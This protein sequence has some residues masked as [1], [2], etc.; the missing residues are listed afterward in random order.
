[1]S[2]K[3]SMPQERLL[4]WLGN[5]SASLEKAWD[6]TREISL[7]GISE[8]LGV[9]RSA[10]NVPLTQLEKQDLVFKRMAH[11]IGGGS[12]RRNVYHLTEEGRK[13]LS[14]LGDDTSKPRKSS[15]EGRMFGDAPTL[16]TVYGRSSLI[17]TVFDEIHQQHCLFISGLPG[18][19]KT[20]VGLAAAGKLVSNGLNVRWCTANEYS[21]FETLCHSMSILS[22]LP[23]DANALA[24]HLAHECKDEVLVF[25]DVHMISSRHLGTFMAICQHM[26]GLQGPKMM[27]IGRET[28]PGFEAMNRVSIPQLEAKEAAKLLGKTLP[29]KESLHIAERLGGH[30]LALQLYQQDTTLPEENA[31]IQSYVEDVVLSTLDAPTRSG[32]DH[33]VLL[34]QPVEAK[35][36]YDDEV[37][38]TLDDYAFLRWT[39]NMEK[40][41][42][43]HLV[44]NVRRTSMSSAEKQELHRLA[45][46]HWESCAETVDDY[47]VLLFHRICAQSEELDAH[48][49]TAYDRLSPSRS[50]A[51]SV[52]LEQAIEA[53]NAPSHLHYLAAKIALDRCEPKHAHRHLTE[54]E[55]EGS[56][57]QISIG[58]AYLEGRLQDAEKSIEKGFE[59]GNQHQKNQLALSAASRRLDDRISTAL[60]K[61]AAKDIKRYLSHIVLPEDAEQRAVT[62]VAL[63][64]VQHAIALAERDFSK[65]DTLRANLSSI[66]S[67]KSGI[68]MGL[69]AKS[70]LIQMQENPTGLP[71]VIESTLQ[72]IDVQP[73]PTH[74]D[75]LRL[76]LVEALLELDVDLAQKHFKNVTKPNS[77]PGS[78]MLH[79]LHARWWFCKSHLHPSLKKVALKEAI[80]QH[81]AAGCPR[82]ANHLEALL[83]S[84]L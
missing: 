72:A 73:S 27:F 55:D 45:V 10:L 60:S 24:E 51:L 42:I 50:S 47:V 11:V 74:Q 40:M 53:S 41:E 44:R 22:E 34:P 31:D 35:K 19:G 14:T 30:P 8:S 49:T 21:D 25:D 71:N 81:R 46:T 12:R 20:T 2:E 52:L 13:L 64:M 69:E 38:G 37:V 15:S 59:L 79:R 17:D 36:A 29:R 39:S 62:V 65:A 6:V 84:L 70:T 43:Q 28:L 54:I 67:L 33:L 76:S 4:R 56:S 32:M 1:M 68:I 61:D 66:S 75:A 9:V 83:H 26:E 48:C 5:Y 80:T 18:I 58:L 3:L 7:P 63:T 82:A 16:G 77:S 23:S 78:M 57:N